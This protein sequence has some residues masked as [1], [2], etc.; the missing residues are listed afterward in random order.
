M[1]CRPT[2]SLRDVLTLNPYM[3]YDHPEKM[4]C[5]ILSTLRQF[6]EAEEFKERKISDKLPYY[7]P[8]P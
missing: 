8:V 6:R 2:S 1:N 7:L 3:E 5:N 4:T